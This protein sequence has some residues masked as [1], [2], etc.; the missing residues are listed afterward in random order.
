MLSTAMPSGSRAVTQ[1]GSLGF[2]IPVFEPNTTGFAPGQTEAPSVTNRPSETPLQDEEVNARA[3]EPTVAPEPEKQIDF[4]EGSSGREERQAFEPQTAS[5]MAKGFYNA[6]KPRKSAKN[7][8][9]AMVENRRVRDIA[10]EKAA[11]HRADPR[12]PDEIYGTEDPVTEDSHPHTFS[13]QF[14]D[15]GLAIIAD[16]M[17]VRSFQNCLESYVAGESPEKQRSSHRTAETLQRIKEKNP[18]P[19]PHYP[20]DIPQICANWK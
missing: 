13:V 9:P 6:Q 5:I 7:P 1:G 11:R 14:R 19:P 15:P 20:R 8:T 2:P 16:Y 18:I 3:V 12:T 17:G 10:G 4:G